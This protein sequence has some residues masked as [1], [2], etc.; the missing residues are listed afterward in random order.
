M[1][2]VRTRNARRSARTP[3]KTTVTVTPI[4]HSDPIDNHA[5]ARTQH[6]GASSSTY[7]YQYVPHVDSADAAL[8]L[9]TQPPV[10]GDGPGGTGLADGTE[11]RSWAKRHSTIWSR[12]AGPG[13]AEPAITAHRWD[14]TQSVPVSLF[15]VSRLEATASCY[16]TFFC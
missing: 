14:I 1:S 8:D 11:E 3:I 12:P 6:L 13:P 5:T 10:S 16:I 9:T 2:G 15:G 4:L 7:V